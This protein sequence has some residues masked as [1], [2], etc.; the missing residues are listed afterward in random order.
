VDVTTD[1]LIATRAVHLAALILLVGAIVFSVFVAQP[2]YAR[3]GEGAGT[4]LAGLD[5]RV[6]RLTGWSILVALVSG[7]LWLALAAANMSGR[8]LGEVFQGDAIGIVLTRTNFGRVWEMRLVLIALLAGSFFLWRHG[9]GPH[10]HRT[11]LRIGVALLG[12]FALMSLAWAGHASGTDQS[13]RLLHLGS[14]AVHLL[15]GGVWLGALVPL[16][17]VVGRER[18]SATASTLVWDVARRFST[19]GMISVGAV[20]A[21]GLVNAWLLVGNFPALFDTGY[22]QLLLVKVALF[23]IMVG[24]AGVNRFQL[25]PRLLPAA[26]SEAS[27]RDA[28]ARLRRNAIVEL[29]LGVLVVLIVGVLGIMVPPPHIHHHH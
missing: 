17:Y 21:T 3:A 4:Q 24:I 5:V 11:G 10:R 20:L 8:P 26:G 25:T 18:L 12:A 19:L 15:A 27:A 22:G 1:L 2:A 14:D 13:I 9:S 16:A 23:A 29:L 28:G 7:L 6:L